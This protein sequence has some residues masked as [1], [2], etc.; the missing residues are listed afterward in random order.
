MK[1][2]RIS[3]LKARLS[4]YLRSVRKGRTITVLDRSTP[5]AKIIPY[6]SD[7]DD[8]WVVHK[9]AGRTPYHKI[10]LKRLP[11]IDVDIVELLL[12]ERQNGR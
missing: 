3:E 8:D 7:E 10:K 6:E 4:E 9:A 5:I 11:R 12:E 2:V 1:G